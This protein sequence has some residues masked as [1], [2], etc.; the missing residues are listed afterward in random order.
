MRAIC[1]THVGRMLV[2]TLL[3]I[4]LTGCATVHVDPDAALRDRLDRASLVPDLALRV[5]NLVA[6]L[7]LPVSRDSQLAA[8][9][10][11][12]TAIVA[13]LVADDVEHAGL[14]LVAEARAGMYAPLLV[15][16][17]LAADA[18]RIRDAITTAGQA[19]CRVLDASTPYASWL[20]SRYCAYFG[21]ART[22]LALPDRYGSIVV[23]GAIAGETAEDRVAAARVLDAALH[24][25]LWYADG[26]PPLH[27][28][29]SGELHVTLDAHPVERTATWTESVTYTGSVRQWV[30]HDGWVDEPIELHRD[31]PRSLTY[32]AIEH[33]G[34]YASQLH[35]DVEP[36]GIGASESSADARSA[37]DTDV[38]NDDAGIA[39]TR[40]NL[41]T[42]AS[43][44]A[45]ET[46]ALADHL[47]V[48]LARGF[49][50]RACEQGDGSLEAA[51]MCAYADPHASALAAAFGAEAPLLAPLL[52]H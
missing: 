51:A 19:R 41:P 4:A 46:A 37:D 1:A 50:E 15:R 48:A 25:S 11:H 33:D 2:R 20:A 14:P 23:D 40:A 29:L 30:P 27:A 44:A 49:R 24:G 22:P 38:R 42:A 6:A 21:I 13:A 18:A 7:E 26:A 5:Q 34:Q 8:A 43:F 52:D 9:L 17:E 39:P 31:E 16:P 45:D 35:V 3:V 47:H 10:R 32:A 28:T 12:E 36:L